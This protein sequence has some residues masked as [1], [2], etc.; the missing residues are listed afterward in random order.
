MTAELACW[1]VLM[2]AVHADIEHVQGSCRLGSLIDCGCKGCMG[3]SCGDAQCPCAA[4]LGVVLASLHWG[5]M[6]LQG[7]CGR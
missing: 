1:V 7:R 5:L 3:L 4:R 6:L 2:M